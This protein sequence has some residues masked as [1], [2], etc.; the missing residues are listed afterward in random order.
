MT[1]T[2]IAV[3]ATWSFATIEGIEWGWA[4]V[5]WLYNI[6]FYISLDFIKFFIRYVLSRNLWDLVT[7]QRTA[8]TSK[9]N[10][11]KEER[12][13]LWPKEQRNV[14]GLHPLDT[15]MFSV[16]SSYGELNRMAEEARRRAEIS[17]LRELHTP[18][19]H[20]ASMIRLKGL[21]I[22]PIQQSYS[23]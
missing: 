13:L 6:V 19:G 3:Y 18:K 5:I 12:E 9:K 4:G 14:H 10:F 15:N 8:F 22:D 11:G 21:D 23:V 7:E 20:I 1:A 2:L 16:R 17:R